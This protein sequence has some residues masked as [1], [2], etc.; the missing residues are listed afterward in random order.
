AVYADFGFSD[1]LVKLSTRPEKRVGSDESWDKAEAGLAAALEQNGLAFDLQPGEGAFYGPKIEFTLK[2]SLGRLWQVGTIQ[3]DFNLPVRLGA[4]FVDE[5]NT[6]KPPVMLHRAILGSMERFIGI[7]IEHYAGNFPVWLS[8]VQV[9]VMNITDNQAEYAAEIVQNLKKQGVRAV[10]D[11]RNEKIT[12]KIR[13]HSMQRV[14]YKI[15]VGDKERQENKVAVRKRGGE[16]LG[17]MDLE[18]FLGKLRESD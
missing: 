16:D 6:R 2:D 9:V 8:P 4:E 11:L 7:L 10:S 12:Y 15:I 3:L 18:S 14:P 5:D 13:E 17:Q 1:V